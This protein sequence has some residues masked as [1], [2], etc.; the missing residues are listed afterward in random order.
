MRN[1]LTFSL[2]A[3]LISWL[4]SYSQ[5]VFSSE[6]DKLVNSAQYEEDIRPANLLH[7]FIFTHNRKWSKTENPISN[8]SGAHPYLT[9]NAFQTAQ[10]WKSEIK[11]LCNR[12]KETYKEVYER[13]LHEIEAEKHHLHLKVKRTHEAQFQHDIFVHCDEL[14]QKIDQFHAHES[15]AK[16][17]LP[18]L[19]G[20]YQRLF[21]DVSSNEQSAKPF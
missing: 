20:E 8:H 21:N 6:L 17:I 11:P 19:I 1:T 2:S 5:T 7:Q 14:S 15:Q 12:F 16:K 9:I 10:L 18:K 13:E 4:I 3:F